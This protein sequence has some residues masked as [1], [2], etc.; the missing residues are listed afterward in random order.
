M[1][2][3]SVEALEPALN[4]VWPTFRE[5]LPRQMLRRLGLQPRGTEEDGAFVTAIFGF[6]SASK[7][8]YEQFFFDWRGGTA[9]L[10]RAARSPAAGFYA[11]EAFRPVADAMEAYTASAD[12]N[13]DHAY[14][15]RETPRTMLIEDMEAIWAPIAES[16]DWSLFQATLAEIGQMREAY[17]VGCSGLARGSLPLR[18]KGGPGTG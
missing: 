2:L 3:S 12:A 9:S 14:F 8:P 10:A 5:Q 7:A 4:T 6:L 16:D 13:L 11:S 1:P 18:G 15:A 17:G